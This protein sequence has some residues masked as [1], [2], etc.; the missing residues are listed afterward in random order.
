VQI[1]WFTDRGFV[2]HKIRSQGSICNWSAWYDNR[3]LL[4]DSEGFTLAG[5]TVGSAR[6]RLVIGH[7]RLVGSVWRD[8]SLY[9]TTYVRV[10]TLDGIKPGCAF[11]PLNDTYDRVRVVLVDEVLLPVCNGFDVYRG[12]FET[13]IEQ[14]EPIYTC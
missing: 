12:V 6:G 2:I 14:D 11:V 3:G 10:Y 4:Q 9:K 5:K 7:L 1:S 13:K 8:M